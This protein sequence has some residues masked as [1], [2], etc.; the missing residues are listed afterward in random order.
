MQQSLFLKEGISI[1]PP[2][3]E[4]IGLCSKGGKHSE[5]RKVKIDDF[6][7]HTHLTRF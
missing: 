5:P 1:A 3:N 2:L 4:K 6:G 7:E